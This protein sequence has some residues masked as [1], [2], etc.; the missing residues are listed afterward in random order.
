MESVVME[1]ESMEFVK[2]VG[3][4]LAV[5]EWGSFERWKGETFYIEFN[6]IDRE[7]FPINPWHTEYITAE[8]EHHFI[9][10]FPF[11]RCIFRLFS[12]LSRTTPANPARKLYW[13][14]YFIKNSSNKRARKYDNWQYNDTLHTEKD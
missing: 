13:Y 12:L 5:K 6:S 1:G 14:W 9:N 7:Y 10:S 8:Y 11:R 3:F 4:K 2:R